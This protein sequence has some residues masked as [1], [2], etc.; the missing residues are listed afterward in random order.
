M[1]AQ[2]RYPLIL[3][4]TLLFASCS[5]PLQQYEPP[6]PTRLP[7]WD[8]LQ[9]DH[10]AAAVV[11]S[12]DHRI[13]IVWNSGDHA[14]ES[15]HYAHIAVAI[16]DTT[17]AREWQTLT[18][19]DPGEPGTQLEELRV[20]VTRPDRSVQLL[21]ADDIRVERIGKRPVRHHVS[22]PNFENRIVIDFWWSIFGGSGV[23]MR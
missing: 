16:L 12:N 19:D 4:T 7:A 20:S 15:T 17:R 3:A 18:L 9:S 21:T 6:S 5:P 2:T 10:G 22:I 23:P 11:L 13:E 1:T 8:R 14:L